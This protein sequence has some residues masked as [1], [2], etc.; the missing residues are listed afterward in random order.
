MYQAFVIGLGA[1]L[2]VGIGYFVKHTDQIGVVS[3]NLTVQASSMSPDQLRAAVP[4]T[5]VCDT[6]SKCVHPR[7][8]TLN[9]DGSAKMVTNFNND[10]ET[11]EETGTWQVADEG[12]LAITIEGSQAN[13]YVTPVRL[14]T[15]YVSERTIIGGE[16]VGYDNWTNS[17]FKK[18]QE[19]SEQD[20]ASTTAE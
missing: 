1:L 13:Q 3:S 2:I 10:V 16:G 9:A 17:V 4:G 20:T 6:D 8:L 11:L 14:L 5:Y 7:V 18:Q 15:K 19:D 12:K